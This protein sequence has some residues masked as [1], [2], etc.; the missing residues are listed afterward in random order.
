MGFLARLQRFLVVL[1]VAVVLYS[2]WIVAARYA[3]TR[4]WER[5]R[6]TSESAQAARARWFNSVYGGSQVK[7]LQFYARD[8]SVTEGT[9][10]VLC[11]GVL[12]ARAVRIEPP[13]E[14]ASVSPNRCLEVAPS[15]TRSTPLPPRAMTAKRFR[16]RSCCR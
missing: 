6:E 1:A 14:G 13:V 8:A 12:N 4:R 11:Y 16:S 5:R 2:G 3:A 15:T 7:I 9:P 10:S